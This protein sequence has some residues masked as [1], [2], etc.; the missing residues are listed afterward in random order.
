MQPWTIPAGVTSIHV[1]VYGAEG[2]Q[3]GGVGA[4]VV[5]DLTITGGQTLDIHVGG[6]GGAG[7]G[8]FNGGGKGGPGTFAVPDSSGGGGDSDTRLSDGGL[9][10]ARDRAWAGPAVPWLVM[11]GVR[12]HSRR[13][14]R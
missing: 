12:E 8:G 7:N 2:G 9:R 6:A 11:E 3:N 1:V 4:R 14:I 10:N 5:S 13:S